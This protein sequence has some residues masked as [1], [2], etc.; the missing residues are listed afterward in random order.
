M[1]A[2]EHA[3]MVANV[4]SGFDIRIRLTN[5]WCCW[6]I[7]AF[8]RW[9]KSVPTI[10]TLPEHEYADAETQK[11]AIATLAR[12]RRLKLVEVSNDEVWME[13]RDNALVCYGVQKHL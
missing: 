6:S 13:T 1:G 5:H 9:S 12:K 8:L 7:S 2:N 10:Y 3:N 11:K 4:D